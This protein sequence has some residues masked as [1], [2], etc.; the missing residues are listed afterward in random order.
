MA[1]LGL[2]M[3]TAAGAQAGSAT[4]IDASTVRVFAIGTVGTETI[5]LRQLRVNVATANAGHGTGFIVEGGLVMTAQHVV[6]GARHVVVRLPGDA[7][8]FA[9]R[10]VWGDHDNDVAVLALDSNGQASVPGALTLSDAKP[11]VRSTVFAIGYPIDA[12]RK[13]PQSARGIV[14]G[15]LD[16][17]TVQLDMALNPGNSGGPIVDEHDAVIGMAIARGAVDKGVQGIGYA[18]PVTKLRSALAEAKQRLH[19]DDATP[20]SRDSAM[21]VD[22]LVQHGAFYELKKTADLGT[23]APGSD[24]EKP[25]AALIARIQDPDLLVFVAAAMWNAALVVQ[26]GDGK[27]QGTTLAPGQVAL[28]ANRLRASSVSACRRALEL[29]STVAARSSFVQVATGTA[30]SATSASPPPPDVDSGGDVTSSPA[31]AHIYKSTALRA[32]PALRFNPDSGNLAFGVTVGVGI[33]MST[34]HARVRPTFGAAVGAVEVDG[35]TGHFVHALFAAELGLTA[36]FG[37]A[38]LDV[39]FAPCWYRSSVSSA[40]TGPAMGVASGITTSFRAALGYD[41]GALQVGTGVRM[42]DGP[43]FWLEPLYL[44]LQF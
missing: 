33:A 32:A 17:G 44:A 23:G 38:H 40:T 30:L 42:L 16:D 29:D 26:F 21:V 36:R 9:A 1:V 35:M 22:E 19:A 34:S 18:V 7:G 27:V 24:I 11:R 31:F 13:Q 43:T 5:E 20:T 37:D 14:A 12:T 41:L 39:E 8:F 15:F 10:V 3:A 2:I 6:E 4:S 25:L 28:L